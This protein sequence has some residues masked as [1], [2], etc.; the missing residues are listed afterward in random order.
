MAYN[1]LLKAEV[2]ISCPRLEQMKLAK[3][4]AAIHLPGISSGV[5]VAV[6]VERFLTEPEGPRRVVR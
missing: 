5:E 4:D 3:S 2:L 1:Q 6:L